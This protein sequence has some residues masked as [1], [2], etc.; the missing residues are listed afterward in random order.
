MSYL[1]DL[2][3]NV[4]TRNFVA[5]A[6]VKEN[7]ATS[8]AVC[9]RIAPIMWRLRT[10]QDGVGPNNSSHGYADAIYRHSDQYD[11]IDE[12]GKLYGRG[13]WFPGDFTIGLTSGQ[14]GKQFAKTGKSDN[15][16]EITTPSGRVVLPAKGRA[17]AYVKSSYERLL[18]DNRVW[19]GKDGSNKPCIKRFL[20][21]IESNGVV[22]MTTWHYDEVGENRIAAQEVK[23]FNS[24][25]PFSTP[26]P[27][28]LIQRILAIGSNPGDLVLDSFAGSG[29]TGPLPTR[30]AASGSWWNLASTATT[31]I[32]RLNN[33]NDGDDQAGTQGGQ[34]ERRRVSLL[35]VADVDRRGRMGNL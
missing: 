25:D 5:K 24:D 20:S 8:N 18:A 30:L 32:P 9:C 29:T 27:E 1:K 19:F 34:L 26:K 15:I 7:I 12:N 16:Y 31:I 33:V 3:K 6:F 17:W 22:P 2:C 35:P 28:G 10:E 14:R 4:R 23:A 21:E 11:G 13:P